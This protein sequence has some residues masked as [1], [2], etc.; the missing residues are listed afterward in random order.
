[1]WNLILHL[2]LIIAYLSP[3]L[4]VNCIGLDTFVLDLLRLLLKTPSSVLSCVFLTH[5]VSS[6]WVVLCYFGLV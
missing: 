2:F 6:Q 5:L 4:G 1:M 3:N